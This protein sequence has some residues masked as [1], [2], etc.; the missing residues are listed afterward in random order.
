MAVSARAAIG[1]NSILAAV[2]SLAALG[3]AAELAARHPLRLD[4]TEEGAATLDP[5]TLAA[6]ALLGEADRTVSLTA[7]SSQARDEEA[8][9]R[10]RAIR[11]AL[12]VL[13]QASDR[14]ETRFVDLD[15]DRLTAERLAVDRYG[16]LV[17]ESGGERVDV[18]ER[19][20]FRGSGP[21]GRRE[22]AFV[23]EPAIAAAIRQVVHPV[24]R[25][26]YFLAGHGEVAPFDR[27][28]GELHGLADR[29]DEQGWVART[30]DL[31]RD[32][33]AGRAPS[34]PDDAAAV[35]AIG[36]RAALGAPEEQAL[37]GYLG[38]GGGVGWFV[39]PGAELPTFLEELGVGVDD[40]VAMDPRSQFPHLDRPVLAYGR[41]AITE[42]PAKDD[43]A[44]VVSTA[45]PLSTSP[46][47]GVEA[48]TLLQTGPRGWSERGTEQPP[49]PTDGVD[50]AGPVVVAVA[51]GVAAPHP[52]A[53]PG[54]RG[55]AVVVGDVD[56]VRDELLDGSP[57]NATFVTNVLR[58]LV[59][60][61]TPLARV[62]RPRR[63]RTLELDE[64]RLDVVRWLLL[65]GM[66]A[67]AAAG[68]IVV[69]LARR[70]R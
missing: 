45:A 12:A 22:V 41:H 49:T 69:W 60:S 67:L 61:D 20:L 43:L 37:R 63:V 31:Q 28:L 38:R 6:L 35:V 53:S 10:D 2:V 56:L 55:R 24:T 4:L 9:L 62:G 64:G 50:G 68:G 5:D 57:G 13:E 65:G 59:G 27:G 18:G 39:D 58:W 17:V 16:T 52:T 70:D 51:L 42:A 47:D 48:S 30:L 25:V 7:F 26:V 33:D 32:V 66:P 19:D 23:G 15:R 54:S 14:V 21:K 34:V 29:V 46:R 36:P 3:G 1:A 8:A 40:G 44:T 11:D